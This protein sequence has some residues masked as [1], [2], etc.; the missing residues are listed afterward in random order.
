MTVQRLQP[1]TPIEIVH[2]IVP[3][4]GSEARWGFG[5]ECGSKWHKGCAGSEEPEIR[6]VTVHYPGV[7]IQWSKYP[8]GVYPGTD[9]KTPPRAIEDNPVLYRIVKTEGI[10]A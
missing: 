5:F 3:L 4:D 1:G 7:Q 10:R 6:Y 9:T 2:V 8:D